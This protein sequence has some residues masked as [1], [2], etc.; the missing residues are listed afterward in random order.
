ML[1]WQ[2]QQRIINIKYNNHQNSTIILQGYKTNAI[3][4]YMDLWNTEL[5][6]KS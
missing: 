5:S 1:Q 4:I 2:C 3:K 6:K